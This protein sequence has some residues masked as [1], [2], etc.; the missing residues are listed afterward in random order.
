MIFLDIQL[1]N[2]HFCWEENILIHSSTSSAISPSSILNRYLGVHTKTHMDRG[3][4][5]K[6]MKVIVNECGI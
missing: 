2:L 1:Y 4:A 6:A 5:Q 3:G